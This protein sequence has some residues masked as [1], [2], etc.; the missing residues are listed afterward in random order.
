MKS[1]ILLSLLATVVAFQASVPAQRS[2]STGLTMAAGPSS[3]NKNKGGNP[4]S[5]F[6]RQVSNNFQP[7]HGHGSLE[8]DLEEQWEAQQDILRSRRAHH[9]DKDHLKKK[10]SDPSKAKFDG[11][12]GDSSFSEFGKN[13]KP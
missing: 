2:T 10:Y 11:R 4:M 8:N 5:E 3:S 7:F 12:V 6:L 13:L 1:V 9:L